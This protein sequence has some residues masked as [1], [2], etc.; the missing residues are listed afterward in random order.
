MLEET[1]Q[2]L[3]QREVNMYVKKDDDKHIVVKAPGAY[4]SFETPQEFKTFL[5][6][7]MRFDERL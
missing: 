5:K 7:L 3:R 1:G 2:I 4:F 6:M